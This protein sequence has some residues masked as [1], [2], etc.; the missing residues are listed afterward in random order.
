MSDRKSV[1]K[2]IQ[3]FQKNKHTPALAYETVKLHVVVLLLFRGRQQLHHQFLSYHLRTAAVQS[4]RGS[5]IKHLTPI[6]QYL[7]VQEQ[8]VYL[9]KM[10]KWKMG[11]NLPSQIWNYCFPSSFSS[12]FSPCL[13]QTCLM[14]PWYEWPLPEWLVTEITLAEQNVSSVLQ[15]SGCYRALTHEFRWDLL[16]HYL[17]K[18]WT[19]YMGELVL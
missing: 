16:M 4:E 13:A 18:N 3:E 1:V 9:P 14:Q 19:K 7:R 12:S 5:A 10:L 6:Y 15:C 2:S 11:K 8:Q 17:T